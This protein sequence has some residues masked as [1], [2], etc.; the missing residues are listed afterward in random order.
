M[1]VLDNA[2]HEAFA[3]HLAKGMPASEAY[4]KAGYAESRSSA[5]R[6]LT[7]A[8]IA[9]RVAEL[10]TM[11]AERVVV[12]REWV[13]AKLIENASQADNLNASNKALE[14]VG[15]E[16]GMFV[17]RSENVNTNYNISDEPLTDDEW[18]AE[19]ATQH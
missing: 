9:A 7:N 1:P 11:T 14:L 18:T 2:R 8:N 13:L 6:L 4:A 15:K 5:S 19:H 10:K 16:L 12:D 17:D 3:Q